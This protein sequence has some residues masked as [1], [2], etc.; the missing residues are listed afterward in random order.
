MP[1]FCTELLD[2]QQ[3]VILRVSAAGW[4]GEL[5]PYP[6]SPTFNIPSY[7]T[8]NGACVRNSQDKGQLVKNVPRTP[9][10]QL[11]AADAE[12][13][14]MRKSYRN[15]LSPVIWANVN[16]N[17]KYFP[18]LL[19]DP[20]VNCFQLQSSESLTTPPFDSNLLGKR[21]T[22]LTPSVW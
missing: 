6:H 13:V 5:P 4:P 12:G 3:F 18:F 9:L 20:N 11:C 17:H 10:S 19:Q 8:A 21:T 15:C 16:T 2:N 1:P 22:C 7:K 14:M